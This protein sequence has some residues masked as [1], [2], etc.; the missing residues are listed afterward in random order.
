MWRTRNLRFLLTTLASALMLVGLAA[1]SRADL[2]SGSRSATDATQI[3]ATQQWLTSPFTISWT[4]TQ[5][6]PQNGFVVWNYDYILSGMTKTLSHLVLQLSNPFKIDTTTND[7][8]KTDLFNLS[9]SSGLTL[10]SDSPKLWVPPNG[11]SLE[12]MPS[13]LYGMKLDYGGSG[14]SVEI[15]FDSYRAPTWGSFYAQDGKNGPGKPVYAYNTDF[16]GSSTA[17]DAP[18]LISTPDTRRVPK[19]P[20][21]PEPSTLAIAALG[22]LGFLGYGLRRRMAK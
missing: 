2:L 17:T 6:A 16:G 4:V 15:K 3:V 11:T 8:N 1:D 12:N 21:V 20:S 18:G 5:E 7:P 19:T 10:D 22:F 13:S 14:T 9:L